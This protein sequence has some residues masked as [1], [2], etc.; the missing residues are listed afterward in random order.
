MT[1]K[2]RCNLHR[3]KNIALVVIAPDSVERGIVSDLIDYYSQQHNALIIGARLKYLSDYELELFY[4]Y[5]FREKI[6]KENF[7]CWWLINRV[8]NGF[9]CIALMLYCEK[10]EEE[11]FIDTILRYKGSN[12]VKCSPVDETVRERFGGIGPILSVVHSSDNFVFLQREALLFF[13]AH[14]LELI[15]SN[16]CTYVSSDNIATMIRPLLQDSSEKF[17]HSLLLRISSSLQTYYPKSLEMH[18]ILNSILYADALDFCAI[19]TTIE[20]I[21]RTDTRV[22]LY[23]EIIKALYEKDSFNFRKDYKHQLRKSNLLLTDWEELLLLNY[24]LF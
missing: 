22:G 11:T 8:F 14:E 16:N 4:G 2:L 15:F 19:K 24:M 6:I 23:F 21:T 3:M 18:K 9:P 1:G 7:S 17:R 13:C 5:I 20:Y 10:Y 12:T